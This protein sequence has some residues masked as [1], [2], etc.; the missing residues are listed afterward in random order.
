MDEKVKQE[1][2][3]FLWYSY[4]GISIKNAEKM[5]EKKLCEKDRK[6]L[7]IICAK[8]AY[9]DMNRTLKFKSDERNNFCA[10]ICNVIAEEMEILLNSNPENFDKSHEAVCEK[11]IDKAKSKYVLKEEFHY[12]QAQKWLN[13]TIKYMWLMGFWKD[14][15][16]KLEPVLHV[17]VDRYIIE[18]VWDNEDVIL[19]LIPEKICKNGKRGAY[20]D[21][22]VKSWGKWER[23]E[24]INFQNSLREKLNGE[25]PIKWE[26]SVW[27]E[28]AQ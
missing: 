22:K 6:N 12:G 8:K 7:V 28:V 11:I 21:E 5:C 26:S 16:T 25:I 27:I 2:L 15:Y 9:L 19:P 10:D 1:T 24:Y 3:E 20:S 23:E 17:P 4:F 13:M 14:K 18:A